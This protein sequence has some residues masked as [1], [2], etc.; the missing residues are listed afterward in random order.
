MLYT[1]AIRIIMALMAVGQQFALSD[2]PKFGDVR[3]LS[4][5]LTNACSD[6]FAFGLGVGDAAQLT[7]R[8]AARTNNK[9]LYYYDGRLILAAIAALEGLET[10]TGFGPPHSGDEFKDSSAE[11]TAAA[12]RLG[13]AFPGASWQSS[14]AHAYAAENG[15]QQDQKQTLAYLDSRL[16]YH[17]GTS[18]EQIINVRLAFGVVKGFL[19]ALYG[20]IMLLL[21][22][23]D[24]TNA[25]VFEFLGSLYAV[26]A[27]CGMIVFLAW[28]ADDVAERVQKITDQ[29]NDLATSPPPE[30]GLR[31]ARL[32]S[33][34]ASPVSGSRAIS[35]LT[36]TEVF[37]RSGPTATPGRPDSPYPSRQHRAT[38]QLLPAG[39]RSAPTAAATPAGTAP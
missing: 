21:A 1:D 36:P 28:R 22:A 19:V 16:A 20:I 35:N 14:A 33:A 13:S 32:A 12:E 4:A 25:A 26:A 29:Y 18:A 3:Y 8:T 7:G 10:L 6:L 34:G 5:S 15:N 30:P 31:Q 11:L 17:L 23:K 37:A 39:T 38:P 24:A 2:D 9:Y 27:G